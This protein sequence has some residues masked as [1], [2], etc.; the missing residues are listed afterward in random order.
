MLKNTTQPTTVMTGLS[1]SGKVSS[2]T[3][4]GYLP[5]YRSSAAASLAPTISNAPTGRNADSTTKSQLW[6]ESTF[7]SSDEGENRPLS[8]FTSLESLGA[9]GYMRYL[10]QKADDD[11]KIIEQGW[12]AGTTS[13]GPVIPGTDW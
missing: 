6:K 9:E 4:T 8:G 12:N 10:T 13:T 7:S 5:H 1:I 11:K 2:A 3:A